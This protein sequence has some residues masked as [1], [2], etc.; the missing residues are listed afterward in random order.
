[1]GRWDENGWK[2]ILHFRRNLTRE[3]INQ[4]DDL[5]S[6]INSQ[7]ITHLFNKRVSIDSQ[8]FFKVKNCYMETFGC[9]V[10]IH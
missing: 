7:S 2:W 1:M 10:T 8:D 9:M 6:I 3:L 4:V 5:Y